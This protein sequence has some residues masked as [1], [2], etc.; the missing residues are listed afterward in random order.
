[1]CKWGFK[2]D[3]S[4]GK[5]IPDYDVLL[6]A[7]NT[8]EDLEFFQQQDN[9]VAFNVFMFAVWVGCFV[10]AAAAGGTVF[11]RRKQYVKEEGEN[12]YQALLAGA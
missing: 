12:H 9:A 6:A 5:C 1:M 4:T 7:G 3:D 10:I 8:T 2:Y 11:L